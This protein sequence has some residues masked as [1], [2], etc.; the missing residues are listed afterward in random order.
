MVK[1]LVI[2]EV[3]VTSKVVCECGEEITICG[4]EYGP[5]VLFY[6]VDIF[7]PHCGKAGSLAIDIEAVV[8]D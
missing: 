2:N 4:N 7:C 3:T 1:Q 5:D 6:V 8:Y